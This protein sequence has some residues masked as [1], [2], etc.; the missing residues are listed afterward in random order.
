M[1]TNCV[2]CFTRP[3]T[4]NDLVC[5]QCRN[6]RRAEPER[7]EFAVGQVWIGARHTA[8]G[9]DR[10]EILAMEST[11]IRWRDAECHEYVCWTDAAAFGAWARELEVPERANA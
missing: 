7:A 1:S 5:D 6:E 11:R 9:A 8:M 10:R 2:R 4:G 3:R